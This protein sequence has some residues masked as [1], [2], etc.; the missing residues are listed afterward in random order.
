MK[1]RRWGNYNV[2][3]A[4]GF[5]ILSAYS[6]AQGSELFF[7]FETGMIF[8]GFEIHSYNDFWA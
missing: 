4:V 3:V 6:R 2:L 7:P 1:Y 5:G 8:Q